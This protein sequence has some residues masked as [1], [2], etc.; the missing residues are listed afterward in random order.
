MTGEVREDRNLRSD[1]P[2]PASEDIH[3][4]GPSYLPIALGVGIAL[5]VIGV[6]LSWLVLA[7]GLIVFLVTLV[8]W[9]RTGRGELAELP[10]EHR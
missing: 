1:S 5:S 7:F 4:P 9:I 8:L 6:V 2:P 10:L 3:L